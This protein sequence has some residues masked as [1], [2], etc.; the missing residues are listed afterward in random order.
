MSSS[1][2]LFPRAQR[3]LSITIIG[4]YMLFGACLMPSNIF[5]Q[6]PAFLMG[7]GFRGWRAI[8]FFVV[9]GTLDAVIGIALLRLAPWSRMAAIYFFLFRLINTLVTF[10]LPGSRARFEE[11]VA[12]MQRSMGE[13]STPR[14]PI[15][16]GP[17]CEVSLMAVVLWFLFTRKEAFRAPSEGPGLAL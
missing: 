16:F 11:G 3:P 12:V 10:L 2:A 15:W 8:L 17:A 7:A 4:L 9:M 6:A 1:R 14:S 13:A 5:T